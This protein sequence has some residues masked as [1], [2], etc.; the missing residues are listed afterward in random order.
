[1]STY[2]IQVHHVDRYEFEADSADEAIKRAKDCVTDNY[3]P[4]Y[5]A[6]A[7]FDAVRIDIPT[8]GDMS[9]AGMDGA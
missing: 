6:R 7:T 9:D 1:M 2:I 4:F 8:V 5:R 3:G